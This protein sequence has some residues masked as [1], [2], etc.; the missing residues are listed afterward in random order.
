M[1][2]AGL[3]AS[4]K[5]FMRKNLS[6]ILWGLLFIGVGVGLIGN[7]FKIWDYTVFFAGW[8]TLFIILP[9]LVSIIQSGARTGNLIAL[10]V[11]VL[12]LLDQ[13]NVIPDRLLYKFAV[14]GVLIIIGLVILSKVAFKRPA[15]SGTSGFSGASVNTEDNPNYFAIFSG[16]TVKNNSTDLKGGNVTAL[17]G[18]NEIDLSDAVLNKDIDFSVT[19]IFGGSEI[20]APKCARVEMQGLPIFGG[21][22]NTAV[23]SADP[24]AHK[25]TFHC[26]SIFGGTEIK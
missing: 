15:S 26:T 9:A 1:Y 11:G 17:F 24:Q 7:I 16:N 23:S 10:A 22:D 18:G 21:N 12:L 14:P 2:D 25:I 20:R 3:A 6:N 5:I 8:W 4:Y 19:S 13:Q